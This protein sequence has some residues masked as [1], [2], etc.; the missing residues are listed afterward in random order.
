M[1]KTTAWQMYL[2]MKRI[3]ELVSAKVL[4]RQNK[5]ELGTKIKDYLEVI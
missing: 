1:F 2:Q 4:S 5:E 3:S